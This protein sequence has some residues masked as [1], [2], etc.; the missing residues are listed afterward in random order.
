MQTRKIRSKCAAHLHNTDG[1]DVTILLDGFDELPED[2]QDGGFITDLLEHKVLLSCNII[3]SSHPNASAH[4]HNDVLLRVDILG[5]TEE[6]REC[7]IK[8]SFNSEPKNANTLLQYLKNHPT[9]S[10]LCFVP[11]IMSVLLFLFKVGKN[12]F[13]SLTELYTHFVCVT[14]C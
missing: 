5:F 2:L 11:F 4:L 6:D 3:A 14:I 9:I 10:S 8:E 13:E 12:L 7:Y 1:K